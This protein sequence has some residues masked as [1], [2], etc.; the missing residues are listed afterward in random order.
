MENSNIIQI[1]NSYILGSIPWIEQKIIMS[2][3]HCN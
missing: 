3:F 1:I 2:Q